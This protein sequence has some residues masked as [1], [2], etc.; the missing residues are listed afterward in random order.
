V[1]A[2]AWESE[3]EWVLASESE[4]ELALEWEWE[5]ESEWVLEWE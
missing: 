5:S 1:L 3:S 4:R 2:S